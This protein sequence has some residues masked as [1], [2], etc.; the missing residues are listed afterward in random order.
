MHA[1]THGMY[2]HHKRVC[3]GGLL[4]EKKKQPPC[5]TGE[6]N[7]HQ[8][9]V[10]MTLY[11]LS[12]IWKLLHLH[13]VHYHHPL[14][15]HWFITT[16]HHIILTS[17][18][19]LHPHWVI[20]THYI[21]TASWLHHTG[22][23]LQPQHTHDSHCHILDLNCCWLSWRKVWYGKQRNPHTLYY[24]RPEVIYCEECTSFPWKRV[25]TKSRTHIMNHEIPWWHP[26]N[27]KNTH[28]MTFIVVL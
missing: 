6:L 5:C 13:W 15:P 1:I 19:T 16:P 24:H 27:I 12:S 4:W 22:L 25:P 21:H 23:S 8:Q 26:Q 9:R 7:L 2:E 17:Y 10:G 20:I 18:I 3:T 11:Q 14:H 28:S